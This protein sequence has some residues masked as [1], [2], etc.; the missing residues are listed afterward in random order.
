MK[1]HICFL[2]DH[3]CL[4]GNM[5]QHPPHR[6]YLI[7]ISL[8]KELFT[9]STILEIIDSN[10][11]HSMLNVKGVY[12]SILIDPLSNLG[13][14]LKAVLKNKGKTKTLYKFDQSELLNNL[15]DNLSEKDIIECS[16][17]IQKLLL[18]EKVQVQNV[19]FR[20]GRALEIIFQSDDLD[21]S[22]KDLY[23]QIGLS[24]SN[25]H[26]LFKENIGIPFRRFLLWLKLKRSINA[27]INGSSFTDAAQIG[28][29]SD[30]AH[31]ARNF[32]DNVG[33]N[34]TTLFKNKRFVQVHGKELL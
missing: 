12:F 2:K 15:S 24:E 34:L 23:S 30:S 20:I 21:I 4:F 5:V 17:Y 18:K 6:H 26:K 31:L 25:F 3:I 9:R 28:S 22:A 33:I 16:E 7:Q 13:K 8:R 10:T 14:V 32:K 19:D 29:F 1:H 11:L 27:I